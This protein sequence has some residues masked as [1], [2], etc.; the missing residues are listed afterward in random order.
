MSQAPQQQSDLYY[1][2]GSYGAPLDP[3]KPIKVTVTDLDIS[4]GNLVLLMVKA[5]IAAIP[6]VIIL[7]V[8]GTMAYAMIVGAMR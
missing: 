5:A 7:T 3:R 6:A 1:P 2:S 8:A 4:L